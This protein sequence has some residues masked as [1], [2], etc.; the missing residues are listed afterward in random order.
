MS[1]DCILT[2]PKYKLKN[3]GSH[4][5]SDKAVLHS[6]GFVQVSHKDGEEWV[7]DTFGNLEKWVD[8]TDTTPPSDDYPTQ[9][10][11]G[12]KASDIP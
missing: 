5:E 2:E 9:E 6:T 12:I 7:N 4:I 3:D 10:A 11:E 8:K 1:V